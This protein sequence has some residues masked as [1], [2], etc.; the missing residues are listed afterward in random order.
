MSLPPTN[1]MKKYLFRE[2]L[3]IE[4]E[5]SAENEQSVINMGT[6]FVSD[7]LRKGRVSAEIQNNEITHYRIKSQDINAQINN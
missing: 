5:V 3:V 6:D 1:K 7:L 4:L 2:T